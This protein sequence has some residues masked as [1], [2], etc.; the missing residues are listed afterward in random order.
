MNEFI[1]AFQE[2]K[3]IADS[4]IGKVKVQAKRLAYE[5][6]TDGLK[7]G[8]GHAELVA[9]LTQLMGRKYLYP[10]VEYDPAEIARWAAKGY[11]GKTNDSYD[12]PYPR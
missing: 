2:A 11:E 8:S 4:T 9:R 10:G 7:S 12:P 6:W 3:P 5:T 1:G